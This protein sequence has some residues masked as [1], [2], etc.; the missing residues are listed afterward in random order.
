MKLLLRDDKAVRGY[1]SKSQIIR[2]LSENWFVRNM[3]CPA[4]GQYEIHEFA[5]NTPLVDFRCQ[6]C[7]QKYQLKCKGTPF[8][9]KLLDSAHTIM[10]DA[11]NRKIVPNFIFMYY[12]PE[13]LL[14]QN[15]ILVPGYFIGK[16]HIEKRNPLSNEARRRGYVGCNILYSQIPREGKIYIVKN[17]YILR[18]KDVLQQWEDFNFLKL[19]NIEN[20]GWVY[21]ILNCINVLYK[22]IFTLNEIYSF[23]NEL[24]VKHPEN[25]NVKAKIRQQLQV[26]RDKG[27]L[28]FVERGVYKKLWK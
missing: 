1:K 27:L 3:Y 5:D 8:K 2:I 10:I 25:Y 4:C 19:Q 24:A 22:R 17:G 20:R 9:K 6:T 7:H 12:L 13:K 21:D 23:E 14:I 16:E 15:I 18:R 28:E 11:I 26:L